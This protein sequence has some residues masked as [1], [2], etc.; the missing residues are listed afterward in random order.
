M[1]DVRMVQRVTAPEPVLPAHLATKN[2]VDSTFIP[3]TARGIANGVA[4]L[5]SG[6]L[7]P[8]ANL[9]TG[10]SATTVALGNDPRFTDA[11][12]PTAHKTTHATGGSDALTPAD[13]GAVANSGAE[14]IA[15]VK[16]FSSSPI[17]PT[18]TTATQAATKA[19]AD[20]MVPLTQRA[21]ASGVAT[22]DSGTKVPIAQIPTGTTSTTVSLG[23]HNHALS[24]L[25]G[26]SLT[27]PVA[28]QIL[29]YNGTNWVNAKRI[30]LPPVTLT[31]A[32][33]IATDAS[34]GN[35]FRV[36]LGGN[37]TLGAPTNPVDGQKAIWEVIQDATGSRT[38][39]LTT[40]SNGAFAYGT[41]ITGITL[42]TTASKRDF[43]GAVYNSTAQR[44]Y[45]IAY[46]KGY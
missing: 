29:G 3:L 2:Y 13:I 23:D 42:T 16:T 24:S 11:R 25:T 19:Y 4:P 12:T 38:L 15:G 22:L 18:P 20:L 32:A 37:R 1:T 27:S 46:M 6:L 28:Q 17:V 21:A 45:V 7:V 30:A 34:L 39:T 31:D 40:G 14:T 36:T 35:H 9:P 44:W 5:D 33:T 41:D 26:V 43:I 8:I 10:T